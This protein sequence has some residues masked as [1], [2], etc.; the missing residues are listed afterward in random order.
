MNWQP[1][2]TAPKD[3][4]WLLLFRPGKEGNRIA[5]ARWRGN[6]MDKGS[7]E[8]GGNSWCYPENSQPTHWMPLPPPPKEQP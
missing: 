3:G 2:D 7:Y 4:T 5:E 1:I 6:W 8:W